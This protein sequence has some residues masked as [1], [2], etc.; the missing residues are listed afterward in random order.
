M[1]CY[2]ADDDVLMEMEEA[3]EGWTILVTGV[4]Q[5]AEERDVLDLFGEFGEV[6]SL[7]LNLN[8]RTGYLMG[9]AL[10]EYDNFEAA[11]DAISTMNGTE[12]FDSTISV[13]WAFCCD[14][15]NASY[16]RWIPTFT[17]IKDYNQEILILSWFVNSMTRGGGFT[18]SK[19]LYIA[20][21]E[22]SLLEMSSNCFK[23]FEGCMVMCFTYTLWKCRMVLSDYFQFT[24]SF[25]ST[26]WSFYAYA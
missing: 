1:E 6:E 22:E 19:L 17:P 9:Y 11:Q 8:H 7:H 18:L 4:H 12:L 16:L 23:K 25:F 5:E 21:L 3:V 20:S 14:P 10:I 13:D 15:S 26:H 24:G 2:D